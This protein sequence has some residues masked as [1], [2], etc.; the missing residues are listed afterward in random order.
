MANPNPSPETRFKEGNPGGP[1]GPPG[2]QKN[3]LA[4]GVAGAIKDIA[5][6]RPLRGDLATIQHRYADEVA[7][8][9]GRVDAQRWLAGAFL[10]IS[11]GLL[12]VI[13]HAIE[14]GEREK[15]V[16]YIKHFGTLGSKAGAELSRLEE[17][18]DER[19]DRALDYAEL[20]KQ[21]ERQA[22]DD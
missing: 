21:M 10:A 15:A 7:S 19:A 14:Q 22:K 16:A 2:N 4:G 12:A 8:H 9:A 17:M 1:G 13:Q 18:A 3:M 20:V 5:A 6:G 11:E